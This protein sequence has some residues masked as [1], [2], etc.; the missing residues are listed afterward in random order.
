MCDS[1]LIVS[2]IACVCM[3]AK[4]DLFARVLGTVGSVYIHNDSNF[5]FKTSRKFDLT[6]GLIEKLV[7]MCCDGRFSP[8]IVESVF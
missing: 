5:I 6:L 2:I 8:P 3:Y 4:Y 1:V 7:F